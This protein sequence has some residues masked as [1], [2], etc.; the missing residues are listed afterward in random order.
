MAV[1]W[2]ICGEKRNKK[3][4]KQPKEKEKEKKGYPICRA[5]SSSELPPSVWC[6]E[7]VQKV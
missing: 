2:E 4:G 6:D 7:K 5:Y 1:V 3:K